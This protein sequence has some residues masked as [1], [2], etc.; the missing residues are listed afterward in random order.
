MRGS[1]L[2]Q[3]HTYNGVTSHTSGIN[4][5]SCQSWVRPLGR[6]IGTDHYNNKGMNN[7]NIKIRLFPCQKININDIFNNEV[8]EKKGIIYARHFFW[9]LCFGLQIFNLIELFQWRVCRQ[10]FF[11]L[12]SIFA[13]SYKTLIESALLPITSAC[14]STTPPLSVS[15]HVSIIYELSTLSV[16]KS[17]FLWTFEKTATFAT[18][19]YD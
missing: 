8:V 7:S 15:K 2:P 6:G 17:T 18:V 16:N 3:S 1:N 13:R 10:R 11:F 19:L 12:T 9:R 4:C 5:T 14:R